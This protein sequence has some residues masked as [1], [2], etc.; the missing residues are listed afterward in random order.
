MKGMQNSLFTTLIVEFG[1]EVK[2]MSCGMNYKSSGSFFLALKLWEQ[3][4]I[5]HHSVKEKAAP[6]PP[7]SV[8]LTYPSSPSLWACTLTPS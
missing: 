7:T 1:Y 4:R 8:C 5:H 6:V 3:P 2:N